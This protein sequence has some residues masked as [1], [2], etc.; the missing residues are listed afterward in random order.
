VF[1]QVLLSRLK[2]KGEVLIPKQLVA[3]LEACEGA[4]KG[5]YYVRAVWEYATEY[6]IGSNEGTEAFHTLGRRA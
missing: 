4:L 6:F 1:G 3:R 2:P 5:V